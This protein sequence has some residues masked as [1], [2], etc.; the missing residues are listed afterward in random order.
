MG[1]IRLPR[2]PRTRRWRE[3]VDLLRSPSGTA[4]AVASATLAAVDEAF[5][6]SDTDRGLVRAV[7]LL[8]QLPVAARSDDFRAAAKQLG[9]NL[10]AT[11]TVAD[12]STGISAAI[13][14]YLGESG[15]R[16][17]IGE[18]ALGAAVEAV[19]RT[20]HARTTSLFPDP[21]EPTR[22]TAALGTETQFGRLARDFFA[23]FTQRW[24]KAFVD[25]ELPHHTGEGR[26]FATLTEQREF[27]Q[28]LDLHCQQ[29]ARIVES[30]AGGWWSKARHEGDLT[31]QRT[32][33]FVSYSLKKLRDELQRGHDE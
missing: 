31:E 15:E 25:R 33:G 21:T 9:I 24:L 4:P 12:I 5:V 26:R 23:R 29:A 8:A 3:V 1:H 27:T 18:L 22:A 6:H 14:D 32:S 7:W 16:T 13:D 10:P 11:P 20:L 19:S 17:D 30:F 28:A 2:L